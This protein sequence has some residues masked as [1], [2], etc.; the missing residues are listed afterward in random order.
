MRSYNRLPYAYFIIFENSDG[1]EDLNKSKLQK[2]DESEEARRG[3][4]KQSVVVRNKLELHAGSYSKSRGVCE[5]VFVMMRRLDFVLNSISISIVKY[6]YS[7]II[8][9]FC[10]L[11]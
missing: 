8:P 7:P 1:A 6:C 10:V 3:R 2:T 11:D 4:A 5:G 9:R